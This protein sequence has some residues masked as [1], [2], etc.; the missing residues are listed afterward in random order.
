[1]TYHAIARVF[2]CCFFKWFGICNWQCDLADLNLVVSLTA[3][4][5]VA[6]LLFVF[7]V[8]DVDPIS[9]ALIGWSFFPHLMV[10]CLHFVGK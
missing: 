8:K 3:D 9:Y 10:V 4:L 1:M 6:M 7:E 5:H 2:N